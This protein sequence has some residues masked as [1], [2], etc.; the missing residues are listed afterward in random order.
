MWMSE[1]HSRLHT[2]FGVSPGRG[3]DWIASNTRY[4]TVCGLLKAVCG[5]GIITG[6]M[7]SCADIPYWGLGLLV[8]GVACLIDVCRMSNEFCEEED[9]A[10][11]RR[12]WGVCIS[13]GAERSAAEPAWCERC[14]YEDYGSGRFHKVK[15]VSASVVQEA[16]KRQFSLAFL[17]VVITVASIVSASYHWLQDQGVAISCCLFCLYCTLPNLLCIRQHFRGWVPKLTVVECFVLIFVTGMLASLVLLPATHS[18]HRRPRAV[19]LPAAAP[20]PSTVQPGEEGEK[21]ETKTDCELQ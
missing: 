20:M 8:V 5:M 16:P 1:V 17:M 13:C 9:L 6:A 19:P 14:G 2:L 21:A 3:H 15:F 7:L 10:A 18:G 11:K 4:L 12:F